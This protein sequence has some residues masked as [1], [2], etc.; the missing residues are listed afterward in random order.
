MKSIAWLC[1]ISIE[2]ALA[3]YF[4]IGTVMMAHT[5]ILPIDPAP[6]LMT[7]TN[8]WKGLAVSLPTTLSKG[9]AT[10]YST[11]SVVADYKIRGQ[12]VPTNGIFPMANGKPLDDNAMTC[13]IWIIGKHGRPLLPD[14][15]LVKIN[16][17]QHGKKSRASILCAWT[18]N[19]PGRVPRSRGVVVDLT[20]AAMRVL[21][22]EN[23]IESG[24]VEVTL[25]EI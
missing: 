22:G 15:R 19:G 17:A 16:L 12:A 1:L 10:W 24:R 8:E 23:G 20:P 5:H 13:A 4:A 21:A 18:D 9:W 6:P 2:I 25:E 7:S 14:G 11:N 3:L